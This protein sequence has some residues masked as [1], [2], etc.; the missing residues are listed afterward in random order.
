MKIIYIFFMLILHEI[1]QE[2]NLFNNLNFFR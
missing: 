2:T 1:E